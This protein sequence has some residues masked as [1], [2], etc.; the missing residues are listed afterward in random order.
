MKTTAMNAPTPTIVIR[1]VRI[2]SSSEEY[3]FAMVDAPAPSQWLPCEPSV[4]M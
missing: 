2:A 1:K 4:V 3:A